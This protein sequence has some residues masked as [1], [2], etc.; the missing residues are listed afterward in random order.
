M[1][2][3][4][5][6]EDKCGFRAG[7]TNLYRYV[8]NNPTNATDPS[9]LAEEAA[10]NASMRIMGLKPP[11]RLGDRSD[12]PRPSPPPPGPNAGTGPGNSA[13]LLQGVTSPEGVGIAGMQ[14]VHDGNGQFKE[15][16][17]AFAER[18]KNLYP[19][20]NYPPALRKWVQEA[21][22]HYYWQMMLT[23]RHGPEAAKLIGDYHETGVFGGRVTLDRILDL[24]HNQMARAVAEEMRKA[25]LQA[26]AGNPAPK[27]SWWWTLLVGT[28]TGSP[29]PNTVASEYDIW[30]EKD[31][32][33]RKKVEDT[34]LKLIDDAV[35][36]QGEAG[37]VIVYPDDPYITG[38]LKVP[39][40]TP[41]GHGR[42]G[43]PLR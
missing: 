32:E 16:A 22:R 34:I 23:I 24:H 42:E 38:T 27:P 29:S 4:F 6:L 11:P 21:A 43:W 25:H 20:P 10:A 1:G 14:A 30:K 8:R 33:Y 28:A 3:A 19:N 12:S 18:A 36:R 26:V 7:D 5:Q 41:S 9:G 40:D 15:D 37:K 17:G 35:K 2:R 31:A 13:L 39:P